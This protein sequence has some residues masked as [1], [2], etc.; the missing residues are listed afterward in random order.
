[1]SQTILDLGKTSRCGRQRSGERAENTGG[2]VTEPLDIQRLIGLGG[3]AR[4]LSSEEPMKPLHLLYACFN[5]RSCPLP[6]EGLVRSDLNWEGLIP[7]GEEE[8][9]LPALNARLQ[10]TGISWLLPAEVASFFSAVEELNLE[11]NRAILAELA[12]VAA[13]LNEVGIEPVLLKGAAYLV[14]GV[15][16]S[17]AARYLMD[18]D[19]LIPEPKMSIGIEALIQRG[20][21]WDRRDRLGRFRHHHPPLRRAGSVP[22]ELHHSLGMS[23]CKSLLPASEVLEQSTRH[24]FGGARVRVPSPDHLMVHLI[25]HS[26]IQHPYN[27]RIWPPLR[28]M[29]DLVLI[30]R[31][32]ESEIDWS[33]L[34][35]RFRKAGQSGV[36][37]MHLLRVREVLGAETPFPIRLTGLTRLRWLRRRLLRALPALRFLD[38]IYMYS[39]V[40]VRRLRL[41][42]S[43]LDVP[44]GWRHITRELFAPSI[45]KRLITDVI[46]GRGR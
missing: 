40:L 26:Q 17:P 32:F 36:L 42:R 31:R 12:T 33:S 28:A 24:E 46:E 27:E 29:Y 44:G 5:F 6:C 16:A 19:L 1:L 37:A 3:R 13:L 43:A 18:V 15:Y 2:T 11:R 22:F 7:I 20:F 25:M 14:A 8:R 21:E 35:D 38:P 9:I 34:E 10:E 30:Q 45:Y 41:L 23:S 4:R 39:T